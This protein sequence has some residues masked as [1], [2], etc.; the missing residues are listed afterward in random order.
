MSQIPVSDASVFSKFLVGPPAEA[1]PRWVR[2]QFGDQIIADSRRT[3]LLRQYGPGRLPVY[4]FPQADVR[5]D[6]LSPGSRQARS[7]EKTYWSVQA[8]EQQADNAAWTYVNPPDEISALKDYISFEWN[9][10]DAWYE[11]EEEVFAHARDPYKRVDVMPSFRHVRVEIDGQTIADTRRP[12]ILF[13]TLLP[14]R[15]YLPL[16]DVRLDLL[17]PSDLKTRCP[18]KGLASY[19]S[20]RVGDDVRENVLWSYPEPIPENPKI[21]D[22]MCFFNEKVDLFVDGELQA[23]PQ[24]PWS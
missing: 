17:L 16:E 24:T 15:Y 7:G 3:I 19:W 2:V 23:R 12:H 9:D 21:R 14:I 13:E 5:L 18:Y 11:E 20:V 1:S 22:L 8:G 6:L 10:M 4:Y